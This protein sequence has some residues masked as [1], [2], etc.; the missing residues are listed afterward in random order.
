MAIDQVLISKGPGETRVALLSGDRLTELW[1][2]RTGRDSLVG[3]IYLGRVKAALK[4]L[5]AAFVD[6]GEDRAGFLAL[7]EARPPEVA[8]GLATGAAGGAGD[9][10]GDYVSEGDGV[11]VQVSRDPI[12]DKGAKLTTHVNLAGVR[13]VLRPDQPGVTVARR[14]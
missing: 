1:V 14:I 9:R 3:N 5:D 11:L 6:I 13:L 2:A 4:G 12:E 8:A 10:I 7:P